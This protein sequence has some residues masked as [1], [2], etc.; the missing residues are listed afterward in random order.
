M[1][2]LRGNFPATIDTKGRLKIPTVFKRHLEEQ[3]GCDVYVTSISG[4]NILI[5]PLAKWEEI[6]SK[7][8]TFSRTHPSV[9]KFKQRTSY[10]GQ[11]CG[12][13]AQG[14]V[15][16]PSILRDYHGSLTGEVAVLGNYD[17]L[18]AWRRDEIQHALE[19]EPFTDEDFEALASL[20]V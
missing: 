8:A 20:G 7:I 4:K 5:Y 11:E 18:V 2:R 12:M 14:R 3:Y 10:F 19:E 16:V 1:N 9:M 13:D 17:H 15:R 6:E